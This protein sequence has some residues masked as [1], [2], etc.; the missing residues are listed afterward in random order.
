MQRYLI[1]EPPAAILTMLADALDLVDFGIV[2]LNRDLRA[3]F[4]NRRFL[5]MWDAPPALIVTAPSFRDLLNHAAA[6]GWYN[7]PADELP[8]YLDEREAQVRAG[9]TP[10]A[11]IT[12]ADQRHVLFR[13]VACADG[14][15]IL[16]YADI[17]RE[18]RL[19]ALDVA[20]RVSAE[21]RFNSE[22]LTDQAAH[23]ASLAEAADESA[24]MADA[25][26]LLLEHEVFERRQLEVDLRR[27]ATTDGLTGALNRSEFLVSAQRA[28]EA[29]QG[30][31]QK[32]VVLMVDADHFKAI[33]DR[34][35]HAGGDCALRH[36]VTS[37]RAGLRETDLVGRLG[38]EEFAVLLPDTQPRPAGM[39]AER[40]R[41]RVA[42]APV[43]FGDRLIPMTI[44]IGLAIQLETDRSIEQVMARADEALYRAKGSGRNRVVADQ[45]TEAA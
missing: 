23:L 42:D 17:T 30:T 15:R 37:L 24:R 7:V 27:L 31:G 18:L 40:L 8:A 20:A 29:K 19:E 21:L 45:Q 25:A 43:A 2:L 6:N 16:T 28:M 33:N 4:I 41:A 32:I 34:F 44:S 10:A 12:L 11:I 13:C 3:R 38:G 36:L 9:S 26:R 39:V 22:L 5:E 1:S 14:G 35:G